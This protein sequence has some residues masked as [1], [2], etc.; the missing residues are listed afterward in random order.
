MAD[1]GAWLAED[2]PCIQL[3]CPIHGNCVVCVR[4]HR[5]N[6]SHNPECLQDVL[7]EQIAALARKVEFGVVEERPKPDRGEER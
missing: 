2:C 3:D 7:R 1:E 5:L 4:N 6:E